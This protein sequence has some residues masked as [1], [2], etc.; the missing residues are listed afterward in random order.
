MT[1]ADSE[2]TMSYEA[3]IKTVLFDRK[4]RFN[5]TAIISR[6]R[7]CSFRRS[8]AGPTPTCCSMPTR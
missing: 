6:P 3:G 2:N 7:T 8:A 5:L 4:L 1:T